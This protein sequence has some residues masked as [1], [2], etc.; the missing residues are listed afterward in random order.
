MSDTQFKKLKAMRFESSSKA[1][2]HLPDNIKGYDKR[3]D[4]SLV[5]S[6]TEEG[7]DTGYTTPADYECCVTQEAYLE[8]TTP[9]IASPNRTLSSRTA[10]RREQ[11][12]RDDALRK[13]TGTLPGYDSQEGEDYSPS[14]LEVESVVRGATR[15]RNVADVFPQPKC[16]GPPADFEKSTTKAQPSPSFMEV[17]P[18]NLALHLQKADTA[19]MAMKQ[20]QTSSTSSTSPPTAPRSSQGRYQTRTLPA[21]SA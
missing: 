6:T 10:A 4:G 1:A 7:I 14:T 12:S 19:D 5:S 21:T 3:A 20:V 13:T 16:S 11:T 9:S 15:G 2:A 18:G 17:D 8:S